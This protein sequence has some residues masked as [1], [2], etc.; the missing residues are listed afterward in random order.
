M[1]ITYTIDKSLYLNIT[2]KC[3]NNCS[4]CIRS[5]S[6]TVGDADNLWLERE[7]S[8][9]EIICDIEK[10]N[11][12]DFNEVVFCGYGEPLERA[13]DVVRICKY[14]KDKYNIKIRINT[15]GL[16]NKINNRDIT[17]EL[18]GLVDIISIS[19]NAKNAEDYDKI[20]K[21]V[22]GLEA[23]EHI[24][25][26]TRACLDKITTVLMTVVDVLPAEDVAQCEK[27]AKDIGA[28]FRLRNQY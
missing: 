21:S 3:P 11:I 24:L 28:E 12:N 10:R 15:N 16:G 8:F 22:F 9:D 17:N 1:T 25:E 27:I 18:A 7:P 2:N 5:Y 4:F 26:F 13:D 23:F 6:D 20:C 19:L 14:I